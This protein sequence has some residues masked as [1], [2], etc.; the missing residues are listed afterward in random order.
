MTPGAVDAEDLLMVL[1]EATGA[2]T[3][4]RDAGILCAAARRPDAVIF[5]EDVYLT[6]A[7]RV[8]ALLHGVIRWQPLDM[9]NARLAWRA[10][11][12]S[13]GRVGLVLEM[14]EA[15]RRKVTDEITSSAIDSVDEIVIRLAPYMRVLA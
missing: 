12:I 10:V 11:A 15:E 4:V 1:G 7:R 13:L 9:R 14:P 5:G 6:I 3:R 2:Q 8:S